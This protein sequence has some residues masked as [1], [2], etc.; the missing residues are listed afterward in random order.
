LFNGITKLIS[1]LGYLGVAA[2]TFIEN[3]IPPIPSELVIPL[4]GFVAAQGKLNLWIVVMAASAGALGGAV[5][6]YAVGRKIG[7]QRLRSWVDRH[8]YWVTL[9]CKDIDKA[10]EWFARHGAISVFLGRL[11][12]GVR[13]FISIPAGLTGMSAIPFIL[14]SAGGTVLWTTL[15][16]LAG[17][18]L[19]SNFRIVEKY[20]DV[21]ADIVLAIFIAMLIFRY[22]TQ[23]RAR[24]AERQ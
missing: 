23:W 1:S 20:V 2:L 8:G 4:A 11:I 3:V 13:T 15:L 6:W 16:A 24:R 5:M 19:E 10:Q 12:P 7:E 9:D 21:L 14:Y 18:I 22:V 17:K